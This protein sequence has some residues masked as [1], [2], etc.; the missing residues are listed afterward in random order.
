MS[1]TTSAATPIAWGFSNDRILSAHNGY[2]TFSY[3]DRKDHDRKKTMTL[4]AHEFIR[5]FLLHVLP[6][7][8]VRC[9]TSV[10]WP[11]DPKAFSQSAVNS[12]AWIPLCPSY[13][14]NQFTS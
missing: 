8:F 11:T 3:R 4:D 9:V 14:Q 5:R 10:S 13:P 2:V 1:W 12:W 6:E 7:G